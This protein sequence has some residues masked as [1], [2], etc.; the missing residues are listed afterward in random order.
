MRVNLSLFPCN[1]QVLI[2]HIKNLDRAYEFAER[3]NEPDVWSQLAAA[4]IK[5]GMVK[6]AIDSYIKANDP[7]TY[8]EVVEAA[9][10]SGKIPWSIV[11]LLVIHINL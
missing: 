11:K 4:Q 3:C 1:I 10:E 6:E 7:S 5:A 9:S 8:L 2:E